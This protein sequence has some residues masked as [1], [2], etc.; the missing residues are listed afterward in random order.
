M[1][2]QA[3][4]VDAWLKRNQSRVHTD[5]NGVTSGPK[6]AEGPHLGVPRPTPLGPLAPLGFR[7]RV[8][9][10]LGLVADATYYF[11]APERKGNQVAWLA[12]AQLV[13]H[14]AD[15]TVLQFMSPRP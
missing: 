10:S 14:L 1:R 2:N 15:P 13:G 8:G 12:R 3:N 7:D 4:T 9:K 11:V 6:W 5:L